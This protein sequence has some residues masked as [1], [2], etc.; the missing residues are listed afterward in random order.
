MKQITFFRQG[1]LWNQDDKVNQNS[2]I[3]WQLNMLK[4]SFCRSSVLRTLWKE[5]ICCSN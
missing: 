3:F 5:C 4:Q 2:Q 1:I